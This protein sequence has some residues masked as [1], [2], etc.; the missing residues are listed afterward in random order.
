VCREIEDE[1]AAIKGRGGHVKKL[2]I[3]GY[4]MGGVYARYAI[5]LLHANGT[6]DQ[7]QCMVRWISLS[8]RSPSAKLTVC[9]NFTAFASPLLGARSPTKGWRNHAWNGVASRML[10]KTGRQIF[11]LDK[12]RDTNQPILAVLADPDSIFIHGLARFERRTLYANV[13][14]DRSAPYYTT[15]ISKTDPY[16]DL[17]KIK[18]R[19]AKGYEDVV[20]D[21]DFPVAPLPAGSIKKE[22]TWA[23]T[24]HFL[25]NLPLLMG[26][27][28][29]VPMGLSVFLVNEG[30]Q[31]VRSAQRIK[32]HDEGRAGFDNSRYHVAFWMNRVK[33]TVDETFETLAGSQ[34]QEYLS[35]DSETEATPLDSQKRQIMKLERRMSKSE[36]PTLALAPEQFS[37]IRALD[38]LGWRKYP[39]WIKKVRHTHAAIIVRWDTDR[40][41]EGRKVIKH[42]VREEFLV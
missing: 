41:E 10:S 42:W 17:S 23:S 38:D 27:M 5:G 8:R 26:L 33:N 20:L 37:A 31:A 19:Y 28:V 30:F 14:N 15:S 25:K 11:L 16:D 39:V 1:L 4:S 13:T 3:V 35:S 6:L 36:E 7:L 24:A 2:S 34:D 21:K 9:Q 32:S 22:D 40:F 29:I 12:F 18:V